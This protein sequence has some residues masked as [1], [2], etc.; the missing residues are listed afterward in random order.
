VATKGTRRLRNAQTCYHVH[1]TASPVKLLQLHCLDG[2][3]CKTPRALQ[4]SARC[5]DWQARTGNAQGGRLEVEECSSLRVPASATDKFLGRRIV[6]LRTSAGL[7]GGELA[8]Q[9]GI[10]AHSLAEIESGDARIDAALLARTATV[11]KTD[12]FYFFDATPPGTPVT[13]AHVDDLRFACVEE[14]MDATD[15]TLLRMVLSLFWVL[16]EEGKTGL[17]A[18]AAIAAQHNPG[19]R[20]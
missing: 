10:S 19:D 13:A 3:V 8:D 5:E 4:K 15:T 16:R 12:V 1:R 11:L 9:L 17:E 7:A 20:D 18:L 14:V 2:G 6:E